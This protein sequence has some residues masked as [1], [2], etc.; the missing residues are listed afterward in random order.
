MSK[1]DKVKV[2]D[3]IIGKY[4]KTSTDWI[5]QARKEIAKLHDNEMTKIFEWSVL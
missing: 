3:N 5:E 1:L 2:V 4:Y